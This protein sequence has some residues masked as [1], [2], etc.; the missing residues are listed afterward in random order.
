MAK[1]DEPGVLLAGQIFGVVPTTDYETKVPTGA[2]VRVLSGEGITEVK[3]NPH[4]LQQ[5]APVQG[6]KVAWIVRYMSWSMEGGSS[7]LS[8]QFVRVIDLGDLNGIHEIISSSEKAPAS[9]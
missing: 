3:L 2:K 8:T 6:D 7:G 4:L 1:I 9:K 5:L